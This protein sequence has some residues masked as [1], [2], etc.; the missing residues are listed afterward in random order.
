MGAEQMSEAGSDEEKE[1]IGEQMQKVQDGIEAKDGWELERYVERALDA[2]RCPPPD[3]KVNVLS[4]G[5]RRRVALCKLLLRKPDLLLL[6]EPTN[7]L[8]AE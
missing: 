3:A 4:G 1:K 2:L 5:E 6:D 8:D 7:H